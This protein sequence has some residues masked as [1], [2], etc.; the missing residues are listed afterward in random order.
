MELHISSMAT[1]TMDR[2]ELLTPDAWHKQHL[3]KLPY[4]PRKP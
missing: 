3:E 2:I 4:I 1:T